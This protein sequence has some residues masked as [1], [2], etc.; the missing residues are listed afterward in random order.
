MELFGDPGFHHHV[1][2]AQFWGVLSL[3]L[4]EDEILPINYT[5]YALETRVYIQQ[6]EQL[7]HSVGAPASISVQ[8]LLDAQQ[9]FLAGSKKISSDA[10]A[11]S[12]S[13]AFITRMVNDRLMQAERGMMSLGGLQ[14]PAEEVTR[15]WYRHMIYAPASHNGYASTQFPGI[16]DAAVW[17]SGR[18]ATDSRWKEV[19][20]QIWE[21][22]R[23]LERAA[24]VLQG[25]FV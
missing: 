25:V 21:A 3:N 8:P 11:A 15:S 9:K 7:L 23:A 10:V 6:I 18:P 13:G 2:M 16:V 1:A 24:R 14:G 4:A 20:H 5:K 12:Q 19:Q 17:A 22:A